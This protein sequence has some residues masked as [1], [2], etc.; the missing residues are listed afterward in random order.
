MH[1]TETRSYW[2]GQYR[3]P[4]ADAELLEIETN[5]C[6]LGELLMQEVVDEP[7]FH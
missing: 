5:L 2:E 1:I 4:I 3:R 6:A 7:E